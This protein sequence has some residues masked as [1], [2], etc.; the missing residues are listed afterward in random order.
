M[1]ILKIQPPALPTMDSSASYTAHSSPNYESVQ[2]TPGSRTY[3]E[4]TSQIWIKRTVPVTPNSSSQQRLQYR[5]AAHQRSLNS[6]G[7]SAMDSPKSSNNSFMKQTRSDTNISSSPASS[8]RISPMR[9]NGNP[10]N[11]T[12]SGTIV[13]DYRQSTAMKRIVNP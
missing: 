5:S 11:L 9:S 13:T 8:N 12:P 1:A 4:Q 3:P 7:S 10:T 6:S 2:T